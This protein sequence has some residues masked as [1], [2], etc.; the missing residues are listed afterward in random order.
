MHNQQQDHNQRSNTSSKTAYQKLSEH[1]E[2]LA[3][4]EGTASML[5]W[6]SAVMMPTGAATSRALHLSTLK[7]LIHQSL[8]DQIVPTLIAEALTQ[9]ELTPWQRAN[10]REIKRSHIHAAAVPTELVKALSQ[11]GSHCEM[12]WRQA[13]QDNDFARLTPAL[14]QVI[15]LTQEVAQIKGEALGCTP[16]E[17]LLDQYEP[18]ASV[19]QIDRIFDTLMQELP[20]IMEAALERQERIDQQGIITLDGSFSISNQKQLGLTLMEALGFDFE[21]GRLDVSLHPFCGGIPSDVRITTRYHEEDFTQS[22]MGIIHETGHA[23]Y[24]QGLPQEWIWQPVGRARGMSVHESQSLFM[25]MQIGRSEA[26]IEYM[27]PIAQNLF[28]GQG[29]GWTSDN[30]YKHYTRVERSLIRVDA[31]EVTYPAHVILRYQLEQALLNGDLLVQ[32]LPTAWNEA[33]QKYVGIQPDQ[34]KNGCMQDIHWMDGSLGYFPTYTLGAM[35]AAQL[36][37]SMRQ[38]LTDCDNQIRQGDFSAILQW[39]RNNVHAHASVYS[40]DE[41]LTQATGRPLEVDPFVQHLKARYT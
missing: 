1:F 41:L 25:E 26:F 27:T 2:H 37:Q 39:L 9:N 34:D 32:D 5:H 22:L 4:L 13:R 21:R 12:I 14:E 30:L 35:T 11:A 15:Q 19:Q 3:H 29:P 38:Q 18:G 10:L 33:M 28:H 20:H 17:A 36:G 40:T 31:D 8:T 16:Y 23:L 6:D 24:E 7:V